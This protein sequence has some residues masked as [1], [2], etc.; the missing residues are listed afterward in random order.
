MEKDDG[1]SETDVVTPHLTE[2][3]MELVW[4][5][6]TIQPASRTILVDPCT[7]NRAINDALTKK[8]ADW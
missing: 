1:L 7:H 2:G 6:I 5:L 3:I 4:E 8:E